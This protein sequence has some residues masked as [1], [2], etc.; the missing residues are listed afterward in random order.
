MSL[1]K[2][3]DLFLKH[4]DQH[5]AM[6]RVNIPESDIK[7]R[8][9]KFKS[10]KR[11]RPTPSKFNVYKKECWRITELQNIKSL[12]NHENRGFRNFHLD[13]IYPIYH[14]FKNNVPPEV[15]GDISNLR[16]IPYKENMRK[17]KHLLCSN[18]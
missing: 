13:H 9:I 8:L 18:V 15:I 2:L 12:P 4:G 7:S 6:A 5:H 14:G 10:N 1:S 11:I 16:F 17:G 3:N